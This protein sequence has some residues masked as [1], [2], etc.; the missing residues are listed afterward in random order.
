MSVFA[1]IRSCSLTSDASAH[2]RRAPRAGQTVAHRVHGVGNLQRAGSAAAAS[3]SAVSSASPPRPGA[4]GAKQPEWSGVTVRSSGCGA[5]RW[6]PG[7][8]EPAERGNRVKNAEK[9]APFF[10]TFG[11]TDGSSERF[12]PV[13]ARVPW[14]GRPCASGTRR[15]P[16]SAGL[17]V[18]RGS[19]HGSLLGLGLG[20][21]VR[22][23]GC[24]RLGSILD[25]SA[26]ASASGSAGS[27]SSGSGSG[28]GSGGVQLG[29]RPLEQVPNEP[30][31]KRIGAA[32]SP[33]RR[34]HW[35]GTVR[36]VS[37]KSLA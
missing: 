31:L 9:K 14:L 32:P 12:G 3:A 27:T 2:V 16:A 5:V 30:R 11:L 10:G 1:S 34:P 36:D 4:R 20:L 25:A 24:L 18:L 13:R 15:A 37:K 22:V 33:W 19:L 23:R 26:S 29:E 7:V 8:R 21:R 17:H 28:S 6:G 35:A